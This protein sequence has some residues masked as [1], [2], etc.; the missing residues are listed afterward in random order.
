M[1]GLEFNRYNVKLSPSQNKE[2]IQIGALC[3]SSIFT[4]RED[5]KQAIL[6]DPLW[7][8]ANTIDEP[9]FDIYPADFQDPDK[10]T[11]MLFVSAEK[12]KQNDI[13]K[14][15]SAIYNGTKKEYPNGTMMAF[16]PLNDGVKYTDEY[17]RKLI[18]NHESY[19]GNEEAISI[20]G[21]Q[22][23]Q[24][25][26]TITTGDTITIRELLKLLPAAPGMSRPQ[27]FQMIEL[28]NTGT[29]TMGIYQAC[30]REL[31]LQRAAD[32]E[33]EIR[34]LLAEGEA[35]KVFH[36]EVLGITIGGT[37]KTKHGKIIV[38][39]EPSQATKDHIHRLNNI[40]HSP[41]KRQQSD[42][43]GNHPQSNKTLRSADTNTH[44]RTSTPQNYTQQGKTYAVAADDRMMCLEER[45]HQQDR[46]NELF[47]NRLLHLET[48]ATRTDNNVAL[49][50]ER[51]EHM[52]ATPLKRKHD[53]TITNTNDI[54]TPQPY[55]TVHQ[56]SGVNSQCLP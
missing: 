55:Q 5:L 50:L 34:M 36:D 15:F 18:H 14:F 21:L 42:E 40:L 53:N 35:K 28:N 12:S 41:K 51:L 17:R 27:L 3:F 2:M 7:N 46:Q 4:Y 16:I 37:Q 6:L 29:V 39:T 10:K 22:E 20:R 11:K 1:E 47:H 52:G 32:I 8:P 25:S 13:A 9:I 30:D 23:L 49:I 48:T 19:I 33:S 54:E 24:Q 38:A 31:V 43:Q 45:F 26:V 56:Y 44:V